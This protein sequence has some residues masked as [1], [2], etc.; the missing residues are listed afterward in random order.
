MGRSYWFEC[1]K[2]GYRAKISGRADRGLNFYVQTIVCHD[3]R[4]LYDAVTRV[5]I[6]NEKPPKLNG[7]WNKS[8]APGFVA[9]KAIPEK[10]PSFHSALNRLQCTGVKAFRWVHFKPQCP[11]SSHHRVQNWNEPNKC[12]RC[13]AHLEKGAVPYRIWD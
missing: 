6:P 7:L 1:S 3:C 5:R 9:R 10:P 11:V 4:E 12:P 8:Q 2:C 13:G